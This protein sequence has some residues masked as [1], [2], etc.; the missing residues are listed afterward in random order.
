[1]IRKL[2]DNGAKTNFGLNFIPQENACEWNN[3][4]SIASALL[5]VRDNDLNSCYNNFSCCWEAMFYDGELEFWEMTL[6]F[7][8]R[9]KMKDNM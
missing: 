5:Q 4:S 3:D 7:V 6:I 1:M 2:L 8:S 9:A